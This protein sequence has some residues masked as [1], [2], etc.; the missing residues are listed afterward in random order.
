MNEFPVSGKATAVSSRKPSFGREI[1]VSAQE[2]TLERI[3]ADQLNQ[4]ALSA[5][6]TPNQKAGKRSAIG[7]G[8]Q[9]LKK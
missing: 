5:S 1:G 3:P 6:V 8:L 2:I 7:T 4:E 9:I